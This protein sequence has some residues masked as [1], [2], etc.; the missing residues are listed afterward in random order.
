ML[1]KIL[2]REGIEEGKKHESFSNVLY[3][4]EK[5]QTEQNKEKVNIFLQTKGMSAC[6]S[7]TV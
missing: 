5:R 3:K 2:V 7:L 6:F 1:S 4:K